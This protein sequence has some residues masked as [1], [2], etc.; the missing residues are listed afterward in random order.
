MDIVSNDPEDYK[1]NSRCNGFI[2]DEAVYM[3]NL[4]LEQFL[5]DIQ[6]ELDQREYGEKE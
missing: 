5:R 3:S 4:V 2:E 1:D 6:G